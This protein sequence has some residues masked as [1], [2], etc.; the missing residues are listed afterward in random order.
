MTRTELLNRLSQLIQQ[1]KKSHPTR[2]AIDGVDN[3]GKTTLAN[4]LAKKLVDTGRSIIRASIDGFHQ[5]KEKRY[6]RG[7][8]S[9][10]G[11]YSDSFDHDSM[12]QQ[13]LIP[14][15]SG[16]NLFYK[17]AV[18]DF[19]TDAPRTE[20]AKLA[21]NNAILIFDGVFLFRPELNE[22]WD[23]RIFLHI[24][25]DTVIE[26]AILRDRSLFGDDKTTVERYTKRYIPGQQMYL[27]RV[28]PNLIVDIVI[29]N[30]DPDYPQILKGMP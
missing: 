23:F 15:G 19:R 20:P 3:A 28:K 9:P 6:R 21:S 14:L 7:H 2:V 8:L 17:T 5:P 16:G 18:F 22:H 26:R 25:S 11:Y 29:D 10:E 13:L 1:I 24:D 12:K 27:Q 4:S 30:T